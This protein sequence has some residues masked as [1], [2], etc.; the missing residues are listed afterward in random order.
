MQGGN[1]LEQVKEKQILKYDDIY[2]IARICCKII[3]VYYGALNFVYK[4]GCLLYMKLNTN[5]KT[6]I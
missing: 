3:Y 5:Q 6:L 2:L 1:M 4:G